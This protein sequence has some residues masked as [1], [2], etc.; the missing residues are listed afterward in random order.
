MIPSVSDEEI[1]SLLLSRLS[2]RRVC[3]SCSDTYHVRSIDPP[4]SQKAGGD[5][6]NGTLVQRKDVV[7]L[8]Q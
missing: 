5:K 2:G 1:V 6:C 7:I 4:E 3:E 8:K